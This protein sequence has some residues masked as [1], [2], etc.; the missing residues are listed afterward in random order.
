MKK[1]SVVLFALAMFLF[2]G[3]AY[4]GLDEGLVAYWPFNGNAND[5]SGNGVPWL[6]HDHILHLVVG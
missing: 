1:F 4:A 5:E 3:V 2:G 6:F